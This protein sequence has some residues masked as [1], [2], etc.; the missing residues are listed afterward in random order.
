[1]ERLDPQGF[2]RL[3]SFH[4]WLFYA[5]SHV[6]VS[7]LHC[8]ISFL[9]SLWI[10]REL[11]PSLLNFVLCV[12]NAVV[13]GTGPRSG[14]GPEFSHRQNLWTAIIRGDFPGDSASSRSRAPFSHTCSVN[15]HLQ[16]EQRNSGTSPE[17]PRNHSKNFWM[18]RI[19][20]HSLG[21]Q[22]PRGRWGVRQ[23]LDSWEVFS[24]RWM[25]DA[26]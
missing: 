22:K 17:Q 10:I 24:N 9:P 13:L 19:L 26:D 7:I 5:D 11:G 8:I 23:L 20:W 25:Q 6:S 1:M 18:L 4:G 14:S 15:K 2:D 3:N 12:I 16:G 21:L